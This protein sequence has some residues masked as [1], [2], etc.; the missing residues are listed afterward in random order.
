MADAKKTPLSREEAIRLIAGSVGD[1][2]LMLLSTGRR[3]TAS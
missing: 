1:A 3:P 2:L